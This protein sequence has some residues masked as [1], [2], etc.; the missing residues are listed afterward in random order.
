MS[1]SHT[2]QAKRGYL[3]N[4]LTIP[5]LIY[6]FQYNPTQL[7]DSKSVTWGKKSLVYQK[8]EIEARGIEGIGAFTSNISGGVGPTFEAGV[9]VLG[10]TFSAADLHKFYAE[11]DRTLSFQIAIDGR[12][13][14]PGEPDRRRNEAGDI[15]ADLAILRSFVYPQVADWLDILG[16]VFGDE[17]DR[18]VKLWFNEPPTALLVLGDLTVEGFVSDLRINETLFNDNLDPVRADVDITLIEKIDSL[19]FA[20]DSVKRI[21]RTFYHTAY[22]DIGNVVL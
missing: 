7:S 22:E 3:A 4:P 6:P 17:C 12:E 20:I 5:P 14:R 8:Q 13:K 18:W 15:L 11:G 21:S 2:V 16:A 1:L 10:R 19:S 9:A